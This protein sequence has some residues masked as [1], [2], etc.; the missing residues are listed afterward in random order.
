MAIH[1]LRQSFL[2][3]INPLSLDHKTAFP[4]VSLSLEGFIEDCADDMA[5]LDIEERLAKT[6]R[7]NR[8]DDARTGGSKVGAHQ[9]A[10]DF[11]HVEHKKS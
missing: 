8:V 10:V 1:S 5:S 2:S 4:K 7:Q 6:L 11:L 9:T 3:Q